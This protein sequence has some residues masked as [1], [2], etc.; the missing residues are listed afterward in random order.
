[1]LKIG[2]EMVEGWFKMAVLNFIEETWV[3]TLS[4]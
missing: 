4:I 2:R 1:M 3:Y